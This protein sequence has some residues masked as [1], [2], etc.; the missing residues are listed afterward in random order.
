[1]VL[2]KVLQQE[3]RKSLVM[4]FQAQGRPE[5]WKPKRFPDGRAILTGRTGN[6]A[7]VVVNVLPDNNGVVM[8]NNVLTNS[9][10]FKHQKGFGRI[11]KREFLVIP[12]SDFPR[13]EKMLAE[14]N[15]MLIR[16]L[17]S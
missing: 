17:G 11:P 15:E 3:V 14:A 16:K 10:A 5:K 12:D 8:G 9:Y 6:L 1:M 7:R 4:N 13:I 2:C